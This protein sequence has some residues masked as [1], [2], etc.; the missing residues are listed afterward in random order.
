MLPPLQKANEM[1]KII[2]QHNKAGRRVMGCVEVKSKPEWWA[3]QPLFK[4][5]A[6]AEL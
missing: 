5:W 3:G 2:V 1:A 6:A 4:Q